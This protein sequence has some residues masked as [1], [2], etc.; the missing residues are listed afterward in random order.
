MIMTVMEA[1]LI[2]FNIILVE[3]EQYHFGAKIVL[4]EDQESYVY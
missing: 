1:G 4:S 3:I 2:I